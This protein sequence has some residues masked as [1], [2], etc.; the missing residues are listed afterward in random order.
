[1]KLMPA[2]SDRVEDR[3]GLVF[4]DVAGTRRPAQLHRAIA[5]HRHRQAGASQFALWQI[6]HAYPSQ[7]SRIQRLNGASEARKSAN[8]SA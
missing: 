7:N 5:K 1:M 3:L 8:S 6:S 4:G 2:S